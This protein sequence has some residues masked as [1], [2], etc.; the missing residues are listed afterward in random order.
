MLAREA[1]QTES[2]NRVMRDTERAM[3]LQRMYVFLE[4]GLLELGLCEVVIL[5]KAL[6]C[7]YI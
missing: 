6:L 7:L 2:M 5:F 4:D 1:M 3:E